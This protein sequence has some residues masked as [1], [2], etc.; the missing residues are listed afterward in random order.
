[1]LRRV[2]IL[3]TDVS[4]ERIASIIRVTRIGELRKTLAV[5]GNR[6]TLRSSVFRYLLYLLYILLFTLYTI[7][8]RNVLLLLV[9]ANIVPS[10][11][12]LVTM[13]VEPAKRPRRR[14]SSLPCAQ[15]IVSHT[16][17]L[18]SSCPHGLTVSYRCCYKTVRSQE[19][20]LLFCSSVM[21]Y[22]HLPL[23]YACCTSCKFDI[24]LFRHGNDIEGR[25]RVKMASIV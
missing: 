3:R 2:I 17:P 9:T 11:P 4:E 5:T 15:Y 23:Y 13:M 6:N 22:T 24:P 20:H 21:F 16:L 7:L 12:I 1:M 14:H 25:L 10:V 8:L 19:P 18:H